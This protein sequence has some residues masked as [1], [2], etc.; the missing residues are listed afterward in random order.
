MNAGANG[1]RSS[2]PGRPA[3]ELG[4]ISQ[5]NACRVDPGST[6]S[7]D[8]ERADSRNRGAIERRDDGCA[9]PCFSL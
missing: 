6:S 5:W 3:K 7:G 4:V 9:V 8:V 2:G 1:S